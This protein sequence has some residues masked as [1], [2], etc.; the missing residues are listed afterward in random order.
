MDVPVLADQQELT[1]NSS[2]RT[3][4][5]LEDL[6]GAMDDRDE[7]REREREREEGERESQGNAC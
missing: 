3:L 2:M 5:S 1:Y 7:W 6:M 4:C